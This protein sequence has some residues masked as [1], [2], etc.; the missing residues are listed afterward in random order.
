MHADREQRRV[1]IREDGF[2]VTEICTQMVG[3]RIISTT[4]VISPSS[5]PSLRHAWSVLT[6]TWKAE[7]R[8]VTARRDG[9]RQAY[10]EGDV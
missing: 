4:A 5:R 2:F 1:F 7:Y 9:K 3:P 8:E 6:S 10:H